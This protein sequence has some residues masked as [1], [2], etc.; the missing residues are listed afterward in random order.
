MGFTVSHLCSIPPGESPPPPP[1]ACFGRDE[2]IEKIIGLAEDLTPVA[3]I[4]PG[5][6]GKTSI[7][8]TVLHHDRVKQRFRDSRWFIRCDQFP[9]SH[10]HLLGRLSKV[11]G[12]SVENPEDLSPLRPFLSSRRMIICLDNA[13]S[14]LDPEGANAQEIY[15]VVEELS[16]FSNICLCIT[17]RISTIP[18]TCET[19]DI[20]TLSIEAARDAFHRIYKNGGQSNLINSI[21][22]KLDFHPLSIT[23]LATVAHHNKWDANRLANEWEK[24]R[25]DVLHTK[26]NNSFAMTIELSLVS[27]M[28]QALGPH[29]R[30]LLEVIAFFP[31]GV[32]ENNL[33]WLFPTLSDG[34]NIFDSFCILSLAYRSNGFITMLA[35]LR[36]YLY[37]KDPTSSLLLCTTRDHYFR[38]L[39]VYVDPGV[40]GFEDTRWITS[41]DVNVEHLL[42]V[43]T[44]IDTEAASAWD[45][46]AC[47]M[48][49][50]YWHKN[51]LVTLGPKIKVLPDDHPS[52][53]QC[54]FELSRLFESVGNPMESKRLLIHALGL[55]REQGDEF[56][57]AGTLRLISNANRQL[58]LYK[59]GIEHAAE[60]LEI[61]KRLDD[62]S[63]QAGSWQQLGWLLYEDERFDTAEEAASRVID[64]LSDASD[65]F[66]VCGCY[67]LLGRICRSK[68]ETEKAIK[69]F[70]ISLGIASSFNWY[71]HMFWNN[72]DLAVLFFGEKRFDDVH[73]YVERAK[74]YAVNDSYP[75]GRVMELQAGFWYEEGKLEEAKSEALRAVGV[76]EGIGAA[77][78]MERCKAILRNIENKVEM[79][80]ASGQPDSNGE[81]LEVMSLS[82]PSNPSFISLRFQTPSH[83]F[84]SV[85]PSTKPTPLLD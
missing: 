19:L 49:H 66:P 52:K 63:G 47:F 65:Q 18:P 79:V 78:N 7:A 30:G 77:K 42:D 48:E 16:Q 61:C 3:L 64:L 70:E 5:G 84:S 59:E 71:G 72:Y 38:R 83:K 34:A 6:I 62:V 15:A 31:Q 74:S 22:K 37:P 76:Y 43:F 69:H 46:C 21:L 50:L 35:P 58:G 85:F 82:T 53:P 17:S 1:R 32:D 54:L 20:P 80:A 4:G 12:A 26:H 8:L 41:E 10:T 39:S 2:L 23:L 56:Q 13:E 33:E 73:I 27:P 81:L 28:F 57:V 14:I 67:N 11:I 68:G 25:T 75:L 44:S 40:P 36:D 55:W 24:R 45:V 9:A 60:S 51:R 29:A